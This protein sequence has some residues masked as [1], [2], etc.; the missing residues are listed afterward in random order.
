MRYIIVG[1]SAAAISAVESI[2]SLDHESRIDLFSDEETPLFSRVLLPYYVAEELSKPLLNFRTSDF[3]DEKMVTPHVGVKVTDVN[4]K[5]KT[6]KAA[7]G[8][9][10]AFDKLLLATGGKAIV[11]PIPGIDKEGISTL[12]TM[13]DAEKILNMKGKRAVVIG[14]GSIGVEACIS[15][16]R[17]GIK[18]TL[19]EQLG[20]V[21]PTV[22]D[23][24]AAAIVQQRI[25]DLG[26]EV[27]TG[28]KA[29]KFTGGKHVRSVVTDTRELPCDMVVLSVGVR[30]ASELALQAGL[31]LGDMKG[32]RVDDCLMTS[33]QDIYAAGDVA[34]TYDIARNTYFLN[35]IWP[36]A[37]EQ[38]NIAGLN[39][40]G[41]KTLYPGSY[42]RNSI[43]NFIGIPAISMGVTHPDACA[44]QSDEDEFREI[45][46]RTKDSY[47]KLILK[48]GKIVGAIL[49]GQ[50][51]KAGLMSILLRKQV[52]V[53]D[54]IPML[55]SDSLSF[56]DLLP[57]LR[58]NADQFSE[59]EYKEL[60]DTGL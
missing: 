25:E 17:R 26:I 38:G 2:R 20:Q 3:F 4:P 9:E 21:M 14:A 57:I 18:A 52:Y 8:K 13:A 22:F 5:D 54:S 31:T 53:A 29:L 7:D 55:M 35:A 60:M 1:G 36:C 23:A 50:T 51:Q 12:K 43:G 48:N 28:E 32:I 45:R 16:M 58:R 44:I 42:R 33:A 49:V 39:M 11:P 19:L 6:I 47:K 15:L 34:E 59:P 10:Y 56:M 30:P 40:A 37:F 27:I 46:V 24:E 41:Q